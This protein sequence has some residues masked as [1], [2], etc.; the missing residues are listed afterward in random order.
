MTAAIALYHGFLAILFIKVRTSL[1][2]R[3]SIQ[4]GWW[5]FKFLFMT[6]FLV[7]AFVI[8]AKAFVGWSYFSLVGAIFFILVQLI[9]LVDLA[10]SLQERWVRNYEQTQDCIWAFLL[11]GGSIAAFAVMIAGY[12]IM[13]IF[14]T[15]CTMNVTLIT[16]AILS[17][18]F[19]TILS[20]IPKL[21]E[22]N[23][24]SGLFQS[25]VVGGFAT[26]LIASA[27]LAEPES[28]HCKKWNTNG[29]LFTTLLG[30]AFSFVAVGYN[31]FSASASSKD[32]GF[33]RRDRTEAAVEK[34][35][36]REQLLHDMRTEAEVAAADG[37]TDESTTTPIMERAGAVVAVAE[38]RSVAQIQGVHS[39][40]EAAE[41][42]LPDSCDD[43]AEGVTY[44]YSFFHLIFVLAALYL[45]MILT[46]WQH[47]SS[48][49]STDS[50]QPINVDYGMTAVW[51]KFASMCVV[52]VIYVWTLI[53]PVL[54]PDRQWV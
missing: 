23:P 38:G 24:R 27:I 16:I 25:A 47:V 35:E 30:V 32:F 42:G 1:D 20:I 28:A 41:L 43:E 54:F 40:E 11:L 14:F 48:S 13:Y 46:N 10:H 2:P 19:V 39:R 49:N 17:V 9:L 36:E 33:G 8:P 26:Y 5:F 45:A 37:P 4:D 52:L 50:S 51:V 18:C 21:Q 22:K 29:S 53:A 31:V 44:S 7:I 12:V 15:E 3:A 6:V 34:E